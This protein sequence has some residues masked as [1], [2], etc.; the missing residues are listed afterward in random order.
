MVARAI[1][2]YV[3]RVLQR[4]VVSQCQDQEATPRG[5][6]AFE[7]HRIRFADGAG[8]STYLPTAGR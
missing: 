4:R 6:G 1:M 2:V 7:N 5:D 8:N 3:G